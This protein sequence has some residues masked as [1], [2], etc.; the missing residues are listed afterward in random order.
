MRY[1]YVVAIACNIPSSA[2]ARKSTSVA[3]QPFLA[4]FIDC[5]CASFMD[6]TTESLSSQAS[7]DMHGPMLLIRKKP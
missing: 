3:T 5:G 2:L 7:I 1:I 6:E 4:M